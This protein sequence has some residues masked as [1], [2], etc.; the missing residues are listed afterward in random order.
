MKLNKSGFTDYDL[1]FLL[2]APVL[3][4]LF[5]SPIA[6]LW[7]WWIGDEPFGT[8]SCG[9]LFYPLV[10]VSIIAF[11]LSFKGLWKVQRFFIRKEVKEE[12][13]IQHLRQPEIEKKRLE[14]RERQ[15]HYDIT[16]D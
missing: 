11:F 6:L 16:E 3:F 1:L 10:F 7:Y 14:Q 15:K 5:M 13:R 8:H 2:I 12:R 9:F 4:F